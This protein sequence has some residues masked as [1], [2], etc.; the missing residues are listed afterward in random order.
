MTHSRLCDIS[1]STVILWSYENTFCVHSQEYHDGCV[2]ILLIENKA[3]IIWVLH[4]ERQLLHPQHYTH[5]SR[6]RMA[7]TDMEEKKLLNKVVIFAFFAHKKYSHRFITLWL[8]HWCHMDYL[9]NV[10]TTFLGL[11]CG[12]YLAVYAGSESSQISSKIS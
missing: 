6:E 9:N 2:C 10:L 8:N 7:K 1:G 11:E 12:S 3:Q 5:A 4:A